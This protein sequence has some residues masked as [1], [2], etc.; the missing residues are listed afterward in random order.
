[1]AKKTNFEVNGNKYFRVT[2]T[3]G[4][5]PDGTPIRK[6]FY[7][8]GINEANEKADE[9]MNRLK[10]GYAVGFEK[11]TVIEAL[12]KWLFSVKHVAVKPATFVTYEANY[13]NY[14]SNSEIA[15]MKISDI[16]KIH[17]QEYYN[18]LFSS[19]KTTEK[20]KAIHKLLHSFFEYAV[21][22]VIKENNFG[23]IDFFSYFE[24]IFM[25][26]NQ[27]NNR[28]I[29]Y[30]NYYLNYALMVS[31]AYLLFLMLMW[32]INFARRF[33]DRGMNYDW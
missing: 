10:S 4:H 16:K 26:D 21:D 25:S 32:F 17:I 18:K 14:I 22:E 8:T 23:H 31:L 12:K 15:A 2:R 5:N 29:G 11:V 7:G 30:V 33:L 13:R 3:V 9:Y 24:S 27:V 6:T 1:M 19:G 20:I 28:Y